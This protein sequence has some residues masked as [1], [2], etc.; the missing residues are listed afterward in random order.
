MANLTT[1]NFQWL[2]GNP[3]RNPGPESDVS[4]PRD[5]DHTSLY[6]LL[7]VSGPDLRV[8]KDGKFDHPELS[9]VE[10]NPGRNPA[11]PRQA[12][13]LRATQSPSPKGSRFKVKVCLWGAR[14][15]M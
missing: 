3:D 15:N 5:T 1:L 11:R 10:G 8:V 9:M 12:A 13:T 4:E 6:L 14:P 7:S 2:K